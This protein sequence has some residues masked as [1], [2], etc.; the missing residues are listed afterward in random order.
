[1][2]IPVFIGTNPSLFSKTT[3][4]NLLV[5]KLQYNM[6]HYKQ[7]RMLTLVQL[8]FAHG[9]NFTCHWFHSNSCLRQKGGFRSS[10]NHGVSVTS[11]VNWL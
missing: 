7:L 2:S 11:L 9:T 3:I 8:N 1:L 4:R 5:T 10:A 6:R